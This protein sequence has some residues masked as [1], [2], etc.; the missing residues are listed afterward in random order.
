[1]SFCAETDWCN[2]PEE[3]FN[4]LVYATHRDILGSIDENVY[5]NWNLGQEMTL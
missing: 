3:E 4:M 5:L 2:K 1:M